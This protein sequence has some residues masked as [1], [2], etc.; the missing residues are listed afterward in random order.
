[1]SSSSKETLR[2]LAMAL[3]LMVTPFTCAAWQVPSTTVTVEIVADDGRVLRQFDVTRAAER[4]TRRAYLEATRGERYGIRV[5]NHS[6]RRIGLVLAVDGRNIISGKKSQ[7]SRTEPMYVL[8][9]YQTATY[10]GWRTSDAQVHRFFFT[11]S[12]D[13]YAGA[14]GD[15]SA[16]GVI[17]VAAFAE[18]A[19]PRRPDHLKEPRRERSEEGDVLPESAGR[20]SKAA[21][22]DEAESRAGTGFGEAQASRAVR[23]QFKPQRQPFA[24]Q[25]FKYEWRETLVR[26]GFIHSP[27]PPNRFWPQQRRALADG[28]APYPPGYWH[29]R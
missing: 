17:A 19:P 24:K 10:D 4:H 22:A 3:A 27:E 16:M 20:A 9:A 28:F 1:M 5:R 15:H 25:F 2:P 7:L 12:E 29:H 26:L 23:V 6:G 18:K 13:S 8:D 21:P 14:F 11:E